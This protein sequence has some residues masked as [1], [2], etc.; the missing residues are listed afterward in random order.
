[1]EN[2]SYI[3]MSR[4]KVLRSQMNNITQNLANMDTNGYKQQN[5]M[6]TDWIAANKDA[7]F[8][9]ER[10]IALV[11]DIGQYRDTTVGNIETTE[12]D[13]DVALTKPDMYFSVDTPNGTRY[14]RN[15]NFSLD[16]GGQLITSEGYPVLTDAGQ[17]LFFGQADTRVTIAGDGTVST[18]V[19]Q[20]GRLA[21]STFDDI[22]Q[23]KPE[24]SSLYN[25]DQQAQAVENPGMVQG[26][27]EK[28]NV[29]P[30][31]AMVDMIEV[32]RSY[33]SV[34]KTIENENQRQRDM[35]SKLGDVR[36]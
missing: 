25:T 1:M 32:L 34:V 29:N 23:L 31:K 15:G 13:F 12:R 17:P 11:Q 4:Q 24:G 33:Q 5:M 27:L 30:I 8:R 26:S 19:G 28:S 18:D 20:V 35:I 6:F 21:V 22:Q 7:P 3:A 9:G 36:A 10:K 2:T 14:T 16:P